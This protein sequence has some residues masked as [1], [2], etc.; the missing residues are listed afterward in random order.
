MGSRLIL[1]HSTSDSSI[2]SV[3]TMGAVSGLRLT[4]AKSMSKSSILFASTTFSKYAHGVSRAFQALMRGFDS[5][6]LLQPLFQC[7]VMVARRAVNPSVLVRVQPLEPTALSVWCNWPARRSP[8]PKVR[9]RVLSPVPDDRV[10]EWRCTGLQPRRR[11]F[12]SRPDL[13]R[14]FS[15]LPSIII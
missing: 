5:R 8:K 13:H 7:G 11:G 4:L 12:D 1:T 2:L 9:V 10:A 6:C 15:P 3:P 14:S